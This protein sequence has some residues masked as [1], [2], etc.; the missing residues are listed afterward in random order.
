MKAL[1]AAGADKPAKNA[2]GKT[3]LEVATGLQAG[4]TQDFY[5]A[6]YQAKIDLLTAR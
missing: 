1:I 4:A 3:P 2:A 6:C 5:R